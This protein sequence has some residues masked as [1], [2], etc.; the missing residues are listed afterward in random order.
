MRDPEGVYLQVKDDLPTVLRLPLEGR[1]EL[2]RAF[3]V[4]YLVVEHGYS[5]ARAHSLVAGNEEGILVMLTEEHES[6]LW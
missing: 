3:L 5:E 2:F 6:G 4:G 1:K